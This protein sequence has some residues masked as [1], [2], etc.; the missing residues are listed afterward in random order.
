MTLTLRHQ[1]QI[2]YVTVAWAGQRSR[3][4]ELPLPVA[5]F[6]MLVISSLALQFAIIMANEALIGCGIFYERYWIGLPGLYVEMVIEAV[7]TGW[8]WV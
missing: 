5:Q 4:E 6:V 3:T 2:G 1:T 8:G 7:S